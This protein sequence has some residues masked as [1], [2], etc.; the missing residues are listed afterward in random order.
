MLQENKV[1]PVVEPRVDIKEVNEKGITYVFTVITKPEVNIKKY[2]KLGVKKDEVKVTKADIKEA[3]EKLLEKYSEL[4]IKETPVKEGDTVTLD[5]E[6]FVDGVAFEGGKSENYSLEIGSHTFIPGFEEQIV[7]MNS[8]EEKDI[9]VTFPEDYGAENLKGKEA[10]FKIKVH[11][12]KEKVSRELDAELFEDLGIEGVDTE[13]KLDEHLKKEL[14]KE[15]EQVAENKYVDALLEE[16]AKNTEVDIPKEMIDEEV[17]HEIH[18]LEENLKRQGMSME[19]YH[20]LT[21]TT[22]E[23]LHK[24]LEPEA[25]KNVKYRLILEELLKKEKIEITDD[26]AKA[27]VKRIASEYQVSE[28]EVMKEYGYLEGVKYDLEM[29]E[30]L[31]KL[32]EYNK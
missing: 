23:D 1:V 17:H 31:N 10:V 16:I 19:L 13:A 7:G 18:H 27:E 30:L 4:V 8:E 9:K 28:D 2:K 6:G 32:K 14:E 25:A 20:Q 15:R 12:I 5:F 3:K 21:K 24:Q 11:E 22:H 29:K 26:Q